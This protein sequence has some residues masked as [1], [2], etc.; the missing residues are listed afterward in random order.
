ML[1]AEVGG[2]R[3]REQNEISEHKKYTTLCNIVQ[4]SK[5]KRRVGAS[6]NQKN[7]ILRE[8]LSR[9][10]VGAVRRPCVG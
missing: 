8:P 6:N 3:E 7:E 5:S 4:Y 2:H 9:P 1:G 10:T